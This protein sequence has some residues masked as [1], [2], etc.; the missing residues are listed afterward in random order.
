MF[1]GLECGPR[2]NVGRADSLHFCW[3]FCRARLIRIA[4][5][6]CLVLN[7]SQNN[8]GR[9]D[10]LHFCW[11]QWWAR[12]H[13]ARPCFS[14]SPSQNNVGACRFHFI[15]CPVL[16]G[17]GSSMCGSSSMFR[18]LNPSLNNSGVAIPLHH[19]CW[20]CWARLTRAARPCLGTHPRR[21]ILG[22]AIHFIFCWGVSGGDSHDAA[23]PCFES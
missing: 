11:S 22:V 10:S 19:F 21:I 18:V 7:P 3:F 15:F 20:Y 17:G 14:L 23:R 5:R 13:T 9:G 4:A 8:S 12:L 16:S 2:T 6:P 1:L